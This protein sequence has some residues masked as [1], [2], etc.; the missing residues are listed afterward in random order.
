M[1]TIERICGEIMKLAPSETEQLVRWMATHV[2]RAT[3][4]SPERP[5]ALSGVTSTPGI[6]G[7]EPRIVNTRIPV[8]T[9]EQM[10]RQGL[11][12]SEILR[13]YPT[14]RAADLV[15]AWAYVDQHGLEIDEQIR[16]NEAS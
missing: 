1:S 6:C 7:G 10:R 3:E 12:E 9:L 2:P 8:W 16:L 14:L 5:Q 15:H 4:L 13:C 11:S